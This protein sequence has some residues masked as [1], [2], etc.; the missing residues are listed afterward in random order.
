MSRTIFPFSNLDLG[1]TD[2]TT[3]TAI[4]NLAVNTPFLTVDG[5]AFF[6]GDDFSHDYEPWVS[7][8]TAAGT[9]MLRDINPYGNSNPDNFT[10]VDGTVFFVSYLTTGIQL[11]KTDG[12]RAGTVLVKDIYTLVTDRAVPAFAALNGLLL[13]QTNDGTHG[14]ELWRSDG[15]AAG[16][17]MLKDIYPG[18][19]NSIPQHMFVFNNALYFAADD[20]THGSELWRSDGT[21]AGTALLKDIYPETPTPGT[22]PSNPAN[23][24]QVGNQ[25]Y[26]TAS[27]TGTGTELWKSDGTAAGTVLVKD[28]NPGAYISS[29]PSYLTNVNGTLFFTASDGVHGKELWKSDGTPG[30]TVMVKDVGAGSL[31]SNPHNE[32]EGVGYGSPHSP[33]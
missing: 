20:G 5:K 22:L 32:D 10:N 11:W 28:I 13:F 12:T 26:F 21:A 4:A 16:T 6:A 1:V 15:T 24:T 2:G 3:S 23:F 19:S 31:G 17:F 18:G 29:E 8:G 33:S 25:F 14:A 9:F 7:D 30:G 27:T